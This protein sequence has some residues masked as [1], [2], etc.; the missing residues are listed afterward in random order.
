MAQPTEICIKF[1]GVLSATSDVENGILSFRLMGSD[2]RAYCLD[3]P[4]SILGALI[5]GLKTQAAHFN[6]SGAA[7]PMRLTHGREFFLNDGQQG[8]EL[9][10]DDTIRLPVVFDSRT[11]SVLRSAIDRLADRNKK[12]PP[13]PKLH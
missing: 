11:I 8:L 9:T 3:F 13:E 10:L 2:N 4:E 5:V 6:P 7:Q 1:T 12:A